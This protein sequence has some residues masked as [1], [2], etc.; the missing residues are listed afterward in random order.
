MKRLLLAGLLQLRRRP[1]VSSASSASALVALNHGDRDRPVDP[2]SVQGSSSSSLS[3]R[4][5]SGQMA[6]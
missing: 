6:V 5:G 2:G 4:R 3:L 1:A